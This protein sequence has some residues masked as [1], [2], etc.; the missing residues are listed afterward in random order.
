M[1]EFRA[2]LYRSFYSTQ[3]ERSL[4]RKAARSITFGLQARVVLMGVEVYIPG[5]LAWNP[6]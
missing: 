5:K 6:K 2:A 4:T 1:Q 3:Q